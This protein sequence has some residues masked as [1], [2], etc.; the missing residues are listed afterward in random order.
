MIRK[1]GSVRQLLSVLL[2]AL[3][4]SGCGKKEA[5]VSSEPAGA[6]V[7]VNGELIGPAP[8]QLLYPG[9]DTVELRATMPGRLP[10]ERTVS[11]KEWKGSLLLTLKP[12]PRLSINCTSRPEGVEV[13]VDSQRR[14]Q[15]PLVLENLE[16]G[17]Y[18]LVFKADGRESVSRS[19][20]LVDADVDVDV[21]LRNLSEG[22]FLRR[23]E[24]EPTVMANY[25]DLTHEYMLDKQ[26]AKAMAVIAR[27]L[28]V[29][30]D[31]RADEEKRFWAEINR[32]T[33]EQYEYGDSSDLQEARRHLRDTLA[34]FVKDRNAPIELY[35]EYIL[36]EAALGNYDTARE[37]MRRATDQR[38]YSRYLRQISQA[39][40]QFR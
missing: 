3:L 11:S 24:E 17:D 1:T 6:S 27:A 38:G 7:W 28:P 13:L 31:G 18:E 21:Y 10:A 34:P 14:G 8:Q 9:G 5:T 32:I 36:V 30:I 25:V 40:M 12:E 35:G 33:V 37:M 22:V 39:M 15:T 26:F 23:I 20:T 4:V 16:P 2:A 29:V 19:V